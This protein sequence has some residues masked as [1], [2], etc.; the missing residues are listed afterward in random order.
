MFPDITTARKLADAH[1]AAWTSMSAD[2]VAERY[3]ETTSFGMNGGEPMT[4]RAEISE[5]ARGF[6]S[7]FP[8]LVLSCDSVLVADHH[9]VYAWTFEGQHA[10]T[11]NKIRFSGWEEWDLNDEL[12]VT[13]SLGW[14]DVEDYNQQVAG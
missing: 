10:G 2:K 9:M 5:M 4:T 14:Y 13:K 3:A 12:K 8:D 11:G 6:M 7:D 1:C